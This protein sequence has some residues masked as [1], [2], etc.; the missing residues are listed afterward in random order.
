MARKKNAEILVEMTT[1]EKSKKSRRKITETPVQTAGE[2]SSINKKDSE[3]LKAHHIIK[4]LHLDDTYYSSNPKELEKILQE[5]NDKLN[6]V[7]IKITASRKTILRIDINEEKFHDVTNRKA[8]RKKKKTDTTIDEINEYRETHTA[9]ET[10]AWLGL[11]RQTYYRKLKE[12]QA[13]GHGG[14]VEF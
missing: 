2:K 4:R 3:E 7:G 1:K 14:D 12:H 8:G 9:M 5:L 13:A 11:T 10:A 6:N